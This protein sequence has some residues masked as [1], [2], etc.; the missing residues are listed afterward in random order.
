MSTGRQARSPV[1]TAGTRA[2][3]QTRLPW[4]ALALPAAAFV[5]LFSL[6][7][8]P[9]SAD[10]G[11]GSGGGTVVRVVQLLQHSAARLAL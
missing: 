7:A 3:Q 6:P 2:R 9:A 10:S 4:W 5:A 8:S 11:R 1:S